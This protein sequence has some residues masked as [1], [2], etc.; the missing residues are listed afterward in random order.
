MYG[1]RRVNIKDIPLPEG[2]ERTKEISLP[3]KYSERAKIIEA[4]RDNLCRFYHREFFNC[5]EGIVGKTNC[6]N[7]KLKNNE[8]VISY[9]DLTQMFVFEKVD[10]LLKNK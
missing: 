8:L 4:E 6:Y 10:N 3:Q 9:K 5:M 7:F 2:Y 1:N